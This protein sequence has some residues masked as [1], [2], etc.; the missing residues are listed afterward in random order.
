M[1]K[2]SMTCSSPASSAAHASTKRPQNVRSNSY[3]NRREH[4][5]GRPFFESPSSAAGTTA[6]EN[7]GAA[8]RRHSP[9][10]WQAYGRSRRHDAEHERAHKHSGEEKKDLVR[11]SVARGRVGGVGVA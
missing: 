6:A 3:S 9:L 4:N 11:G 1:P 7:R 10:H 2:T 5:N 8:I